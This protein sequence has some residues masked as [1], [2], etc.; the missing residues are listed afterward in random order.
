MKKHASKSHVLFRITIQCILIYTIVFHISTSA[1]SQSETNNLSFNYLSIKNGLSQNGVMAI[2]KDSKGF[3]WFGTRDGL[4]RYDGY[5]FEVFRHNILDSTSISNNY[6]RAI[7]E[8]SNGILWIGTENGLNAFDRSTET[9]KAYRHAKHSKTSLSENKILSVLCAKNGDLWIGTENGLNLKKKGSNEFIRYYHNPDDPN[10]I[11]DNH[12]YCLFQDSRGNIWAGTRTGG[13]NKYDLNTNGFEK[14][15]HDSDNSK[16][17]SDN[18]VTAISEAKNGSIWI[19]T[20]KGIN[21]LQA[22]K[23]FNHIYH[24]KNSN[25][26]LSNNFIRALVFDD[27]G[28]LWI[29]T[30]QGLNYLDTSKNKFQVYKHTD[31]ASNSISH[32][33]VRSLF[34]DQNDF[35]WIGTYFGGVNFVNRNSL[36]F[37]YYYHNLLDKN[38]LGYN[39]VGA[40][41]EDDLGNLYVGTEGGGLYHF[42]RSNHNFS[43]IKSFSG[44]PLNIYT[45]KSLLYDSKKRLWIGTYLDGLYVLD[46]KRGTLKSYKEELH[47][48]E[49][50]WDNTVISLLED[51]SGNIWIGTDGGL[52]QYSLETGKLIK[53]DLSTN[54]TMEEPTVKTLYADNKNTLWIGTKSEG[55]IKYTSSSTKNYKY[56]PADSLS[57]T[58]NEINFIKEA[59]SGQLW[60]GTYG[61][62][63][64]LMD[65]EK[66]VFH[67]FTTNDGLVNDIVYGLEED[68]EHKLWISTPSGISKFDYEQRT[69]KNYTSTKGLP[70]EEFNENSI[71]KD[72]K[73]TIYMGGFNGLVAFDPKEIIKTSIKPR[74]VLKNLK[75]FNETI[76][77]GDESGLLETALDQTK[78]IEFS[79][80][81]NVFTIE[82]TAFNYPLSGSNQYAYML[83]GFE[84]KWNYVGNK[85]SATYTNLDAGSYTFK[86]K[87]ANENG[88]WSDDIISLAVVKHPPFWRTTW[89][90]LLYALFALALF[91]IIRK[92]L[93]IKLNL[94]NSLKLEKLEK[95]QIEKLTKLKLSFFTNISHDFRTPLSLIHGPLQELIK[96]NGNSSIHKQLLLIKKNVAL[97]L[98]LIDQLMDFRK[99]ES[100][101]IPLKL[102]DEPFVPFIKEIA[103]SFKEFAKTQNIRY[104]FTSRF[105]NKKVLFDRA[106][107][108]KVLYNI[109]S[110]AFKYTP[111]EGK[112]SVDVYAITLKNQNELTD[113]EN[114]DYVEITVKNTGPGIQKKN[115]D[116]IFD[117]F[118][119]ENNAEVNSQPGT[120]IGLA[121][122]KGLMELHKGYIKVI[123]EPNHYTEFTIGLPLT[124][125]YLDE[126]KISAI[127][128]L[129]LQSKTI[130]P[131]IKDKKTI[132]P[133][134]LLIAEDNHDLRVFLEQALCSDYNIITAPDGKA[135]LGLINSKN[136]PSVIISDIMMPKMSGIELCKALKSNPKT[137]HIPIILLTARSSSSIQMD[138]YD[139]GADDFI[140]KPFDMDMLRT[141]IK[142]LVRSKEQMLEHSRK[143]VLLN[144]SEIDRSSSDDAFLQK[145]SDYIRDNIENPKLNVNK[146]GKD[147]GISRVHLYRKVKAITGK[148][149][150]VFIR[151]FRLAVAAELLEQDNLNINEVCYKV[152]FQDVGYFRKCFKKKYGVSAN[153]FTT[154]EKTKNINL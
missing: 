59:F 84:D 91:L 50:L 5:T 129:K 149:P 82:Y 147:L 136:Y 118:Y 135:A 99:M 15:V 144:E 88:I 86:A 66:E 57:I 121:L 63:L 83:E 153:L 150:V 123:S 61:G 24:K 7:E 9:F 25:N 74:I 60:I 120:G 19:G 65:P 81:D 13:L 92:S 98:R 26:T 94:E 6:I 27:I 102:L 52:N 21:I 110:N 48:Q 38:S 127:E 49:G 39:I 75:L 109:L 4:N 133:H 41:T 117:R 130:P 43:P 17:I 8:D 143:E 139:V 154:R 47:P 71:Y 80:K 53:V 124:D 29:A 89:A 148:T 106:K 55:L 68:N 45:I 22:D 44:K 138:G 1:F 42:N 105:P 141:K 11:S 36:Q 37:S 14:F 56:N 32:N 16:T 64:N 78:T 122:A 115:L 35:L 20:A 151:D 132:H 73:G 51:S 93:L 116:K 31:G 113:T 119:Q 72:S 146:A 62:G 101:K 96:N 134:S 145:L 85:R 90:Y 67:K 69:F 58:H 18:F 111:E 40:I 152:G 77:P 103:Y 76:S 112:I 28:N 12:I 142:N 97:M 10:S 104:T 100:E 87:V 107:I 131:S 137:N 3:M 70:I 126:D 125:V 33:S 46:L 30:Y 23:S 128:T 108:E 79:H 34:F 114:G 95:K 54:L 140:S 2:L